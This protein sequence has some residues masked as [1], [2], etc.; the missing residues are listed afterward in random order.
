MVLL[1]ELGK[2][3]GHM[4]LVCDIVECKNNR[5]GNCT[6]ESIRISWAGGSEFRNGDRA[7]YPVCSDCE[8][9]I[10]EEED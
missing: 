7:Y 9:E 2:G 4:I 5:A 10:E 3:G 1:R 8:E 6:L